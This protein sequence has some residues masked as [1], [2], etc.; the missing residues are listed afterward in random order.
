M[1]MYFNEEEDEAGIIFEREEFGVLIAILENIDFKNDNDIHRV[2]AF[3]DQLQ[4]RPKTAKL[5]LIS[6]HSKKKH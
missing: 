3:I 6:D 1:K 2:V 5:Y 4:T